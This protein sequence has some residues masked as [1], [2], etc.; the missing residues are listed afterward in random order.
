[1]HEKLLKMSRRYLED[2]MVGQTFGSGRLGQ[3]SD[4]GF[5]R[6]IRS[7]AIPSRR[8]RGARHNLRRVGGKRLAYGGS[9][10]AASGR[11]RDRTCRGRRGRRIR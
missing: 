10:H 2:F 8:R 9:H 7:P 1:M 5:C 3:G 6:R 4:Q 11:E